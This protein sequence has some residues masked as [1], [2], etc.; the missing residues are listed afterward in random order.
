GRCG[1][2][3]PRGSDLGAPRTEPEKDPTCVPGD[4][5]CTPSTAPRPAPLPAPAPDPPPADDA[6]VCVRA[7]ESHW[8]ERRLRGEDARHLYRW[9]PGDG[10]AVTALIL[11][12]EED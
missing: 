2:E 8:I 1:P 5:L 6:R 11:G 3:A 10:G 9:V 7:S 12:R 4:P